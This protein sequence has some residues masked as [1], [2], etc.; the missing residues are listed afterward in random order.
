MKKR[1]M[2]WKVTELTTMSILVL[3]IG[4]LGGCG[5]SEKEK[6]VETYQNELD[7][8]REDAEE[9]ADAFEDFYG[10]ENLDDGND[11]EQ[12]VFEEHFQLV[13][14]SAEIVNS[15]IKDPI[16]QIYNTVIPVDGSITV[17][18]MMEE[19]K[20]ATDF[21][22]QY[23]F[24]ENSLLDAASTRENQE[25]M[26][27]K[28]RCLFTFTCTNP[29]NSPKRI[30][31]CPVLDIRGGED[32]HS[33][34]FLYAGN[35]C[36]GTYRIRTTKT[37]KLKDNEMES[38]Q[39]RLQRYP[40]MK[41]EEVPK[42]LETQ[43]FPD[44]QFDNGRAAGGYGVDVLLDGEVYEMDAKQYYLKRSFLFFI[45]LNAA[46]CDT[47]RFESTALPKEYEFESLTSLEGLSDDEVRI[48][49]NAVNDKFANQI[50]EGNTLCGYSNLNGIKLVLIYKKESG[51]F[52]G[53]A[54]DA[55]RYMD[56]SVGPSRIWKDLWGSGIAFYS[57]IDELVA[58]NGLESAQEFSYG[59]GNP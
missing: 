13:E 38:Y 6:A 56:G 55:C 29:E 57:S 4:L 22:L 9:V 30:Y 20:E 45:D 46:E 21:E 28:K 42:Y 7:L 10:D 35:L 52:F 26:D 15:N 16:V 23:T 18:E 14:P 2:K 24:D 54:I 12:P 49:D 59:A 36:T 50:G 43:G 33:L 41:Y 17:G 25:V 8:S 32:T 34:N 11:S 3:S 58:D 47:I 48:L 31:E 51:E 44:V 19:V 39:H 53:V 1:M 37:E 5:K 40:R 27:D